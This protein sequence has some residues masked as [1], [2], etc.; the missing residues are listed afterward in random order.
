[1]SS[2]DQ[3]ALRLRLVY[4][5]RRFLILPLLLGVYLPVKAE[6]DPKV[7]KACLPAADFLGCVKAYTTQSTDSPNLRVIQGKTEV[8]GNMC[9]SGHA[10]RGA[11]YCTNVVCRGDRFRSDPELRNKDWRC[12]LSVITWGNQSVKAV[13]DP[14]CPSRE[15]IIGAPSSCMTQ[16]YLDQKKSAKRNTGMTSPMDMD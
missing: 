8:T 2:E 13:V 16:E 11:G 10:Y 15:P 6:I 9:P 1:M 3:Q 7:R 5:M 12:G 4:F 14:R